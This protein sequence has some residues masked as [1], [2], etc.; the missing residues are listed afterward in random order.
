MLE[1]TLESPL[2]CK[3][4]K[5]VNPKG[6]QSE[7]SLE[8]LRLK[9]KLQ[10]LATW[11]EKPAHWKRPWCWERLKVGGEGDNRGLDG[12]MPSLTR[13]TRVWASSRNGWWTGKPG[14]LWSMGLQSQTPL[15]DWTT[16]TLSFTYCVPTP[17]VNTRHTLSHLMDGDFPGGVVV[18]N[19]PSNSRDTRWIFG[20]G[21]KIPQV[22]CN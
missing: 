8:G 19:M 2:G 6:N 9:L 1:K 13:W 21:T 18:K 11:Y 17:A 3:E 20:W 5:P 16:K 7:Y 14:V 15:S 4:I 12:W 22:C 10:Y